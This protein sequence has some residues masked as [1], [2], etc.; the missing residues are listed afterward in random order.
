MLTTAVRVVAVLGLLGAGLLV[1]S[2]VAGAD[3]GWG[4]VDCTQYPVAGCDLQVGDV[5]GPEHHDRPDGSGAAVECEVGPSWLPAQAVQEGRAG[6]WVWV[7]CPDGDVRFP[8]LVPQPA[9]GAPAP[10][11]APGE[12]AVV[13][14]ARLRL[15]VPLIAANPVGQQLV[16]LPT[17]LWLSSGWTPV[18]ATVTVPGVSVTATALPTTVVWSM[19]DDATVTCAGPGTPFRPGSDPAA[20][21]P[22][23]G[24]TY[25]RSSAG[26][27]HGAFAVSATVHWRVTWSGAGQSGTFPDMTTTGTTG[28]RVAEAPALNNGG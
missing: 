16:N 15:P 25:R 11:L 21:S 23:C 13:A 6:T 10:A 26:Q 7:Y 19:G 22:D 9:A 28:L 3:G 4:G 8:V 17:W 12:V 2:P 1:A 27:T 14:R 5:G 18:A 24:H 20:V